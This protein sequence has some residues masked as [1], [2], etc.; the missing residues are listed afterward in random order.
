MSAS[1]GRAIDGDAH[2][3]QSITDILTT[4]M[5]SRVMRRDYGSLLPE[6]IDQPLVGATR[7]RLFG[8]VAMALMR[9]EPRVRITRVQLVTANGSADG[10]AN[11]AATASSGA[12]ALELDIER[13]DTAQPTT[14]TQLT[15]PLRPALG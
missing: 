14:L 10:S 2:L 11:A 6:L 1:T 15:V 12:F 9:W 5:G 13:T 4:P 8:A 3:R 7:V